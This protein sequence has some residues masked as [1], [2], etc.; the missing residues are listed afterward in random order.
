M[1]TI[2]TLEEFAY[3]IRLEPAAAAKHQ[4]LLELAEGLVVDELGVLDSYSTSAKSVVLAAAARGYYNLLA[5]KREQGIDRKAEPGDRQ[6]AQDLV[7]LTDDEID[8]LGGAVRGPQFAFPGTWPYPDP[9]E[10][11]TD[12]VSWP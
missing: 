3:A 8:Q 7:R 4:L 9:V 5:A 1:T 10:A 11:P 6:A 2:A 12:T